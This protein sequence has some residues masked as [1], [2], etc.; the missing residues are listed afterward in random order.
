MLK[1]LALSV[2]ATVV[3]ALPAG[4]GGDFAKPVRI[5]VLD[6]GMTPRGTYQ[7]ALRLTLA[8]G[9]KTYWRAPGDAGIPPQFDWRRSRNVGDVTITWP[10]PAVFD[11]NG[12]RSI[13]YSD[14]LVLPVEIAPQQ[15]GKPVRLAGV[16]DLGVCKDVCLPSSLRFDHRLDAGAARNPAIV[17]ALA[18]RPYTATEAGVR[19]SVCRLSPTADGLRIEARITMPSAGGR[20]YAVIE[21]GDPRLWASETATGRDGGTLIATGDLVSPDGGGFALDRSKIRITVLGRDRAVDI[22]GCLPG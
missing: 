20:E 14:E 2:L 9:W 13:G 5:E 15:A 1:R 3:L 17:A 10:A 8:D 21:P 4:A 11:Q 16:M 19:R 18:Q 12:L 7:A 6:G 22:Q